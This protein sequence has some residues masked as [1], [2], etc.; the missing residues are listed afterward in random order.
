[1]A[2]ESCLRPYVVTA[3]VDRLSTQA[4]ASL[5]FPASR[6][7]RINAKVSYVEIAHY[8]RCDIVYIVGQR[9]LEESSI[10]MT[11]LIVHI[12]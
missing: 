10:E 4:T 7:L 1:M 6:D 3:L 11:I 5:W 2:F 9:M 8:D 12:L